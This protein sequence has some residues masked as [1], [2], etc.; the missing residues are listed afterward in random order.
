MQSI[1]YLDGW[2]GEERAGDQPFRWM[3]RAARCHLA[4]IPHVGGTWLRVEASHSSSATPVLRVY[5]NGRSAGEHHVRA[6]DSSYL[7]AI[8]EANGALDVDLQLDRTFRVPG[9]DRELGIAVRALEIVVPEQVGQDGWY[10]QERDE[11]FP[12]R[13]MALA[14]RRSVPPGSGRF[15]VLPICSELENGAQTLSLTIGNAPWTDVRLLNGWHVYDLALPAGNGGGTRATSAT[16]E[17]VFR[18]DTCAPLSAHPGDPRELGIKVGDVL[19]HDDGRRHELARKFCDAAMFDPAGGKASSSGS[20]YMPD[21]A[22]GWY[23]WEFQDEIPFRWMQFEARLRIPAVVRGGHQ[24]C[25]VPVF[26]E[27]GDWSQRLTVSRAGQALT[28]VPL[29]RCWSYCTFTLPA[30]TGTPRADTGGGPYDGGDDL[31]LELSLNKIVPSDEQSGDRRELGVRVGPLRFH[32]DETKEAGGRFVRENAALNRREMEAGATVLAS[33]PTNLGI[34]LYAKCN[35]VPP[36]VYCPWDS[37]KEMEGDAVGAVVDERTFEQYG[38]FFQGA[39]TLTNCSFGEP[40]LHPRLAQVLEFFDR[41]DKLVQISSNGQA[42]TPATVQAL[43]GKP[44]SLFVS[45]DSASAATYARLRNDRWDDVIVG[46]TY[47]RDAR[48]RANGLPRLN[49]VFM[50]MRANLH[51]LENYFKLCRMVAADCLVLRPLLRLEQSGIVVDRGGYHYDYNREL[52]DR[53]ELE[54][55]FEQVQRWQRKYRVAVSSQFDFGKF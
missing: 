41:H 49:M 51:D 7:F 47:L 45:L 43:A 50:P 35:I 46:L 3:G 30:R 26:S 40:L 52:L 39:Q 11:Y 15:L 6:D 27:F 19:R 37:M 17:L 44:V 33:F 34:D 25:T 42:F 10:E 48:R 13:W 36:C 18:I 55:V 28:D 2:Y 22:D 53:R 14:A 1:T 21:D 5:A 4:G 20:R 16:P 12:F 8:G 32:D 54:K 29:A 38:P 24:F 23:W 31:V 9:D